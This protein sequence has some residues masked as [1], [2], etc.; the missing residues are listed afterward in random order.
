MKALLQI[1]L[2]AIIF[3]GAVNPLARAATPETD[4]F[5]CRIEVDRLDEALELSGNWLFT[6]E[7][8]IENSN[9]EL[10]TSSWVTVP[11]PGPWAK[12]Y[13]DGKVFTIGWYRGN[14]HFAPELV[15]Q[16]AVF[17]F[18]AYMS[19]VR[20]YIDGQQVFARE[21]RNS[22]ERYF[23]VQPM[24]ITFTISKPLHVISIRVDTPLMS[25][26]YQL[27]FQLR[28][29]TKWDPVINFYQIL[30]GEVRYIAAYICFWSGL[31][32]MLLYW[33]TRY[34][35]YLLAGFMGVGI[36]PF[37]A[38]PNDISVKLFDPKTLLLLHYLGIGFMAYGH[39]A[40]SQHFYIKTPRLNVVYIMGIA[41]ISFGFIGLTIS[42]D[43]R[44]FQILRKAQFAWA[45]VISNHLL[46]NLIRALPRNRSLLPL[47]LGEVAFWIASVHDIALA[48]GL[49]RSTSMIFVGTLFATSAVLFITANIFAETFLQNKKLLKEVEEQN[50][51]LEKT[52]EERTRDLREQSLEL[53]AKNDSLIE[54]KKQIEAQSKK[55]QNLLNTIDQGIFTFNLDL[56]VNEEHSARAEALF[57]S[58]TFANSNLIDILDLPESKSQDFRNWVD[59][60]SKP[61][62]LNRWKR[63]Q[64]LVPVRELV[65]ESN[66]QKQIIS[67]EYQPILE[68]STLHSVMVLAK[69]VSAQRIAEEALR[70]EQLKSARQTEQVMACINNDGNDLQEFFRDAE[71]TIQRLS[72]F[73]AHQTTAAE[74]NDSFRRIHTVKGTGGSLGLTQLAKIAGTLEDRLDK[75]RQGQSEE[76]VNEVEEQR[77]WTESLQELEQELQDI[78]SFH[79]AFRGENKNVMTIDRDLYSTTLVALAGSHEPSYRLVRDLN[80]APLRDL[81][82][83]YQ[84]VVKS[85][86]ERNGKDIDDLVFV[87]PEAVVH[88][89]VMT[90]FDTALIHI[91]RNACDHGI[92]SNEVRAAEGKEIGQISLRY[93]EDAQWFS[94]AVSDNGR[95]IDA[96]RCVE[97]AI[98]R[99]FMTREDAARLSEHERIQLIFLPGLSTRDQVTETSGRGVGMDV[100][101]ATIEK[102]EGDVLV[103]SVLG[104]GTT[105]RLRLPRGVLDLTT[106]SMRVLKTA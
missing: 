20:V 92:E 30:G 74:I 73:R 47:L 101:K 88:R 90:I 66:G 105:I 67:L 28:P 63:Y 22:H 12:A 1:A 21:G 55:V 82:R 17:Y 6:R 36:F 5:S 91:V 97:S 62:Y 56:R 43:E 60:M 99:G 59:L 76:E 38:F 19:P 103:S 83:R 53:A 58:R 57:G 78:R 70:Q 51:N 94:I 54:Q 96:E 14:F 23:S 10:D 34:S 98:V 35:L 50:A 64:E 13:Q 93:E 68:G 37:Y 4:C 77:V 65:R 86:R 18:D 80:K 31:F 9:T 79:G 45:F 48:L 81:C 11:T 72:G 32:F 87:N 15:G 49:I 84:N 24:P 85:Y 8:R 106:G 26:V 102:Y 61:S 42:F 100:V 7:D 104:R 3:L 95:G 29:Y 16:K 40:F 44:T 25:G 69:D 27:P 39:M 52:V 46:Y 71:D 41:L 89:E 75:L 33:K 2:V